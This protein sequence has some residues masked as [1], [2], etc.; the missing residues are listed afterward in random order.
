MYVVYPGK[1]LIKEIEYT[2]S[3]LIEKKSRIIKKSTQMKAR[4]RKKHRTDKA[5]GKN[6]VRYK[7]NPKYI[8]NSIKLKWTK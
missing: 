1:E 6:I 2:T 7:F 3:K 4:K 8:S 5:S